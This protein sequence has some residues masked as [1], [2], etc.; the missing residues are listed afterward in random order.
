MLVPFPDICIENSYLAFVAMPWFHRMW[1]FQG[2]V[3]PQYD[4]VYF[5]VDDTLI[6][7]IRLNVLEVQSV[8]PTTNTMCLL[9]KLKHVLL[10]QLNIPENK[11]N[12]EWALS[13]LLKELVNRRCGEPRDQIFAILA[14]PKTLGPNRKT[15]DRLPFQYPDYSAPVSEV[16]EKSTAWALSVANP[17]I[18]L[19][20]RIS[21]EQKSCRSSR[22]V[23]VLKKTC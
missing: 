19:A 16:Y 10:G 1:T 12:N 8:F 17:T 11:S 21:S 13:S 18:L 7:Y 22:H 20:W 6:S 23:P 5:L 15:S 2:F 3:L 4:I 9:Q 14:I